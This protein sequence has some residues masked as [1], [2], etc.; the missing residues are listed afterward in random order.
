ML[1]STGRTVYPKAIDS[2]N[3]WTI[4]SRERR[5]AD[6][7]AKD[8][9]R[10]AQLP[11]GR[12]LHLVNRFPAI[13]GPAGSGV[14]AL[15]DG[16]GGPE[17][18]AALAMLYLVLITNHPSIVPDLSELAWAASLGEET[19]V[20]LACTYVDRGARLLLDDTHDQLPHLIESALRVARTHRDPRIQHAAVRLTACYD[21][22]STPR[23]YESEEPPRLSLPRGVQQILDALLVVADDGHA[24]GTQVRVLAEDGMGAPGTITGVIW[25]EDGPPISYMVNIRGECGHSVLSPGNLVILGDQEG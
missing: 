17:R 22:L 24:P 10:A 1:A 18:A 8:T 19:A 12:A 13:D 3:R 2:G 23:G 16:L 11:S 7:K 14:G 5:S 20:D 9:R 6:E 15:Y 21:A 4:A 25:D